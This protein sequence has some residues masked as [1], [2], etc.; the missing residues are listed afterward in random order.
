[1]SSIFKKNS[2]KTSKPGSLIRSTPYGDNVPT[3]PRGRA[4]K[5]RKTSSRG[6]TAGR[7]DP[8]IMCISSS[9]IGSNSSALHPHRLPIAIGDWVLQPHHYT[10]LL[11]ASTSRDSN[12]RPSI[13]IPTSTDPGIEMHSREASSDVPP[14]DSVRVGVSSSDSEAN[15]LMEGIT[16]DTILTSALH[17]NLGMTEDMKYWDI[18]AT[19]APPNSPVAIQEGGFSSLMGASMAI[20]EGARGA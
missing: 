11:Q 4:R 17:K 10:A 1:M 15:E 16:Y 13:S 2:H 20:M 6:L 9:S 19:T 18:P 5:S 14:H 3:S 12:E 8:T 7:F